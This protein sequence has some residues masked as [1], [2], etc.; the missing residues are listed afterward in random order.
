VRA[1]DSCVSPYCPSQPGCM[2]GGS[3]QSVPAL[4]RPRVHASVALSNAAHNAPDQTRSR[5]TARTPLR[6]PVGS[7]QSLH[8]IHSNKM[9]LAA[10][11]VAEAEITQ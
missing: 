11:G 6:T 1:I 10:Y 5:Q 4:L 8:G 9:S 7:G 2:A 3:P